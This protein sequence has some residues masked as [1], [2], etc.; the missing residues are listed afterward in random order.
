MKTS[1]A[2][3]FVAA[4]LLCS[5]AANAQKVED[6]LAP[7]PNYSTFRQLLIST[8]IINEVDMR[9]SLTFLMP[10]NDVLNSFVASHQTLT[11]QEVADALRYHVL[12]QYLDVGTL[13]T[14]AYTTGSQV[15]TLYQ[16]T[17]RAN[18]QDGFV[19]ITGM[20]N[21][22]IEVS[23]AA[24][25]SP[26]QAAIITNVTAVP[27]NYSFF[28]IDNV[29]VPNNLK[30]AAPSAAP[31]GA[32]MGAPMMGPSMA[33]AMTPSG[34]GP[35]MAPMSGPSKSPMRA[36]AMSPASMGPGSMAPG[37]SEPMSGAS[38]VQ[39]SGALLVGAILAAVAL[40]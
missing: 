5:V 15:T 32:P 4:L 16:T 21:N 13:Q 36:P 9:S 31:T 1:S 19:N 6:L 25:G 3:L 8:G 26:P 39:S 30:P 29:L 2:Q 24:P 38:M 34:M 20:A 18:G 17:G 10:D 40:L 11:A 28:Q 37:P 33:P 7:F 22:V 23:A 35:K 27:Y 12:L 14:L